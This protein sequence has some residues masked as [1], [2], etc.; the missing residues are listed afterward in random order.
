MYKFK[1]KTLSIY[2]GTSTE[3]RSTCIDNCLCTE[4]M[5]HFLCIYHLSVFV[6]NQLNG[7]THR[8]GTIYILL[9]D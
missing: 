7:I 1:I 9:D 3:L 8:N 2:R 6:L 4:R 5:V